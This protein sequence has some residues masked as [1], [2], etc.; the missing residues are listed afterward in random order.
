MVNDSI[1]PCCAGDFDVCELAGVP[2]INGF[3]SVG[4]R[5]CITRIPDIRDTLWNGTPLGW[6]V[7]N[8][9]AKAEALLRAHAADA[10]EK[11]PKPSPNP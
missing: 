3:V 11:A 10:G 8:S 4:V 2:I 1:Y 6:A 7:H 5:L 9:K